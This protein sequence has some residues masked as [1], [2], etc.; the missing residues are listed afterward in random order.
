M[1]ISHFGKGVVHRM[2][3]V[4]QKGSYSD[5]QIIHD[6]KNLAEALGRAPKR[7]EYVHSGMAIKRFGSWTDT[8]RSAGIEP[9]DIRKSVPKGELIAMLV[10]KTEE[11]GYVPRVSSDEFKHVQQAIG[12][13]GS[14]SAF[15]EAAELKPREPEESVT[16][17]KH[18]KRHTL[19]SL[20][21]L[22][23]QMEEVNGRFP[24]YREY[25]YLESVVQRFQSWYK[26]IAAC[27]AH[28]KNKQ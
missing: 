2:R 22:A 18:R 24:T 4:H 7:R 23:L 13:F 27:E 6:V 19:E 9:L 28:K 1:L 17:S 26:F 14:W 11:L 8:L 5:D 20:I 16:D 12:K 21:G 25:P 10:R 3:K 15:V